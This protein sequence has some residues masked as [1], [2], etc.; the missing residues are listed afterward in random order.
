MSDKAATPTRADAPNSH[1]GSAPQGTTDIIPEA[2]HGR[3]LLPPQSW[4][5]SLDSSE[6]SPAKRSFRPRRGRL[7]P[8][9]PRGPFN[10]VGGDAASSYLQLLVTT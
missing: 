8:T 6:E 4:R 10:V 1:A 7:V 3:F 2:P 5:S 9:L